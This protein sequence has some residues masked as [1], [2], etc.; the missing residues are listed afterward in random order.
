M[1][2]DITMGV[3][4]FLLGLA[5][6]S[7]SNVCILRIPRKESIVFPP[8]SCPHCN[9][10]IRLYDNIPLVSFIFLR[11]RC[12]DCG[13]PISF[14]YPLV[15]AITGILST[16]IFL[17]YGI[18]IYYIIVLLFSIA[19][20]IVSFIDLSHKIIPDVISVPGIV[21]GFLFSFIP[22]NITWVD[23]LIGIFAGGGSLYLVAFFFKIFTGKEGM[24]GGDI[25]LLGMIGAWLGWKALP[26]I[27]LLSSLTGT[28]IGGVTLIMAR[29]GLR[30]QIPFGPFL[31]LG[32]LTYLFFGNEI[33]MWY[34]RLIG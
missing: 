10:K 18:S 27:I 32:A 4:S 12:R 33:A 30:S 7:F 29:R 19:L 25:K 22:G 34:F 8:S 21:A 14:Q 13:N 28:L 5:L 1:N 16:A 11:G 6:G 31:A 26:F 23:S 20:V 15:E 3:F 9:E 24:G 17:K 2:F